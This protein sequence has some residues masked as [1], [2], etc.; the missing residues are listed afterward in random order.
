MVHQ[1]GWLRGW[2]VTKIAFI[3]YFCTGKN[4][5]NAMSVTLHSLRQAIWGFMLSWIVRLPVGANAESHSLHLFD[6]PYA[7]QKC[8]INAIYVT[9]HPLNQ[10]IWWTIWK[11]TFSRNDQP[12]PQQSVISRCPK[13]GCTRKSATFCSLLNCTLVPNKFGRRIAD[14]S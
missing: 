14:R 9:I 10:P 7:V 3:S 8:K 11:C 12:L 4:Q 2:I 13:Y 6:F 5:R 1:I